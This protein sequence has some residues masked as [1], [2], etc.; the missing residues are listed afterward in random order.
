VKPKFTRVQK[1]TLRHFDI[2]RRALNQNLR[3][4]KPIINLTKRASDSNPDHGVYLDY[5]IPPNLA[6]RMSVCVPMFCFC[7]IHIN[8]AKSEK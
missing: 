7:T 4:M 5:D 1:S 3:I 6:L 8:L 2:T